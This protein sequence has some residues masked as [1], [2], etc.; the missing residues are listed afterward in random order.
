MASIEPKSFGIIWE[1]FCKDDGTR[2]GD[3]FEDLIE[4]ILENCIGVPWLDGIFEPWARTP[5]SHDLSR[6]FILIRLDGEAWAECKNHKASPS[7]HVVSTTLA[8][9]TVQGVRSILLFSAEAFNKPAISFFSHFQDANDIAIHAYHGET[10]LSLIADNVGVVENRFPEMTRLLLRERHRLPATNEIDVTVRISQDVDDDERLDRELDQQRANGIPSLRG[11]R[12]LEIYQGQLIVLDVYVTNQDPILDMSGELKITMP[13]RSSLTPLGAAREAM[14]HGQELNIRRAGFRWVR[15]LFRAGDAQT[16]GRFPKVTFSGRRPYEPV[17]TDTL[18][19][20]RRMAAVFIGGERQKMKS[21]VTLSAGAR[22][23]TVFLIVHGKSG[24]GKTRL[25]LEMREPLVTAGRLV[26]TVDCEEVGIRGLRQFARFI[27]RKITPLHVAEY[28]DVLRRA[29]VPNPRHADQR[30]RVLADL[31]NTESGEAPEIDALADL[32]EAVLSVVRRPRAFLIDNLQSLP[33]N[34]VDFLRA[35]DERD[36]RSA[37][38]PLFAIAV[39]EEQAGQGSASRAFLTDMLARG[40]LWSAQSDDAPKYVTFPLTD[41]TSGEVEEFINN[42]LTTKNGK[43]FSHQ[44]PS[45]MRE[46]NRDVVKRPLF[47]EQF[48]SYLNEINAV[49]WDGSTGLMSVSNEKKFQEAIRQAYIGSNLRELLTKRWELIS[50]EMKA[51][52]KRSFR[53]F[54]LLGSIELGHLKIFG[55]PYTHKTDW[56]LRGIARVDDGRLVFHHGQLRRFFFEAFRFSENDILEN[57]KCFQ[58]VVE[59]CDASDL[60]ARYPIAYLTAKASLK[61]LDDE[62]L[63]IADQQVRNDGPEHGLELF[64]QSLFRNLLAGMRAGRL[65][66]RDIDLLRRTA[67]RTR[68]DVRYDVGIA[69]YD[70]GRALL[71]TLIERSDE[72]PAR[73]AFVRFAI[74]NANSYFTGHGDREALTVL[75]EVRRLVRPWP[76]DFPASL[77]SQLEDRRCV[78]LKSLD[79]PTEAA[80]AGRKALRFA[81]RS[82][83]TERAARLVFAYIDIG[84]IFQ[85]GHAPTLEN[86][87]AS[88]GKTRVHNAVY[89]WERARSVFVNN[90]VSTGYDADTRPMVELYHVQSKLWAGDVIGLAD[91]MDEQIRDCRRK[92][93]AFFG[94]K[95]LLLKCIAS[96]QHPELFSNGAPPV[97]LAL[98]ATQWALGHDVRRYIWMTRYMEAKVF[99]AAERHDNA[100]KSFLAAATGLNLAATHRSIEEYHYHFF[101]DLALASRSYEWSGV[102]DRTLELVRSP[103]LRQRL[104]TV[105]DMDRSDFSRFA[106]SYRPTARFHIDTNSPF[107]NLRNRNLPSP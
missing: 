15:Y 69:R 22:N 41:F 70:E 62:E 68:H 59:R 10:L 51:A 104:R 58:R 38:A 74:A 75:D 35:L 16:R 94:V 7:R 12:H 30:P 87:P 85:N 28:P 50:A 81:K 78:A 19:V 34:C 93:R 31:L 83:D 17:I 27:F 99:L 92:N 96:L 90:P 46:L 44:Y 73:L 64:L 20:G 11:K 45:L 23:R 18:T 13:R 66:A 65:S 43:L 79:Q 102:I 8:M 14:L 47:V 105:R 103:M 54:S 76:T 56:L 25:L 4:M 82:H 29:A 55:I 5:R 37:N 21:A 86:T 106:I 48:L 88:R 100:R 9:A 33:R 1:P 32:F 6:D 60:S 3:S 26:H 97:D 71:S 36:I 101:D 91:L 39:N 72:M 49:E 67:E 63:R 61:V 52:E 57:V 98:E 89:Y 24:V 95:H 40:A 107:A 77:L 42:H 2:D 53:L 84:N 80:Q